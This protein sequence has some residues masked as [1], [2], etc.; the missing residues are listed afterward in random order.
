MRHSINLKSLIEN[1]K[2]FFVWFFWEEGWPTKKLIILGAMLL[3][4]I[5]LW[6]I[7]KAKRKVKRREKR[8]AK[9]RTIQDDLNDL[10]K[11]WDSKK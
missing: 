7:I 4:L 11:K 8:K 10:A 2:D 6:L 9:D 3:A 5:L 1:A